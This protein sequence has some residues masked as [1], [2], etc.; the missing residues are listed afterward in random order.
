[1]HP[2]NVTAH[3]GEP[4]LRLGTSVLKRRASLSVSGEVAFASPHGELDQCEGN[5][6]SIPRS[7]AVHD[8]TQVVAHG[9]DRKV[10]PLGDLRIRE[11]LCDPAL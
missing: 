6:G 4:N 8:L 10:Q 3:R 9:V 11:P 7:E 1:M 2:T 5:F